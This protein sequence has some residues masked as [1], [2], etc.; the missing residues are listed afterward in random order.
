MSRVIDIDNTHLHE[1]LFSLS[2][3]SP[4][5]WMLLRSSIMGQGQKVLFL[6][7]MHNFMNLVMSLHHICS[8]FKSPLIILTP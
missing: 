6:H 1:H 7:P 2:V 4:L 3:A 5:N 8:E